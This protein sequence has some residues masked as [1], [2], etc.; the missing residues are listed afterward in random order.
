MADFHV[1]TSD[2]YYTYATHTRDKQ[3]PH[4]NRLPTH[5][6]QTHAIAASAHQHTHSSSSSRSVAMSPPDP[7]PTD[8]ESLS[9]QQLSLVKK[10]LDDELE[11]LSSS[12]AH[13]RAAQAKFRECLRSI[14]AGLAPETP[15][16]PLL[17]PLTT[18]LYVSG[19]LADAD[20]VIVDIGTGF[21][22]EKN[23]K[24]AK[25]FYTGKTE[26]LGVNLKNL[27]AIV[28]AKSNNLRTVED[29]L[30]R[31]SMIE[32]KIAPTATV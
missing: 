23:I 11:H 8:L 31:K 27:E 32:A 3:M 30:R 22:V 7:P 14:D 21:Y 28:Q 16:K 6:R 24:D 4:P 2:R 18:S 19:T 17:V 29:V 1:P 9:L 26:E 12:F 13:L 15:G 10:Q 20:H 5:G 25:D